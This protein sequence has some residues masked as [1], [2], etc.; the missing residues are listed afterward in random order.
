[1]IDLSR[2]IRPG[3]GVWWSQGSAEPT[4]LVHALLDQADRFAPVRAFCGL[5]W[6]ERLTTSLPESVTVMSYGALGALRRLSA[7]GRL[8]VVPCSYSALPRLFA[9]GSL[10]RDVGLVQV[11]P[12]DADGLCSLGVGVDYAA[13]AVAHTPV[14][15]AEVNRRMP[16][17]AGSARIPLGR[18]RAVVETDRPLLDAPQRPPDE[19]ERTIGRRVAGLIEDGDTIQLGVG[20]L[21]SGVL[22]ALTGHADLGVHSGMIS[23]AVLALVD[24]GIITGRRKEIDPGVI[25]TGTA[26]GSQQ[27]YQR[28]PHLPVAF[29]A[30]SYT[31]APGVLAQLRSFVAV[32]SALE[33]DLS[34]QIGAELRRGVYVGA[35]GGQADFS[36][37]ACTTG[38]RSIIAL[39]SRSGGDSAIRPVLHGGVVTTP[40]T[41]VDYV[42]TEYGV[43]RLRGASLAER[44]RRLAAIAAPEYRDA[45]ERAVTG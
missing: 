16:P 26:L 25:V 33:V 18:F 28:I 43:A 7:Q 15:I 6:D 13:D 1:M 21:P 17:T 35:A 45:L 11:S 40:R 38:A 22:Q 39:R 14:L 24:K 37:A 36:R 20:S 31:H 8:T 9:D 12:P 2:H 23:D 41:D 29:L 3:D 32:N 10:P 5:S 44:A 19:A 30:A 4:V 42:V 34:G 27:L